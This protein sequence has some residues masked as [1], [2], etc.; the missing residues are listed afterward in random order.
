MITLNDLTKQAEVCNFKLNRIKHLQ[1]STEKVNTYFNQTFNCSH[2]MN[3]ISQ[4]YEYV[5]LNDNLETNNQIFIHYFRMLEKIMW[6]YNDNLSNYRY[7]IKNLYIL[8]NLLFPHLHDREIKYLINKYNHLS[9]KIPLAGTI[10]VSAN[11]QEVLLVKNNVSNAWSFPKG[12]IECGEQSVDTA[13]RECYEE[14]GINITGKVDISNVIYKQIKG[15]NVHFYIIYLTEQDMND[16][17]LLPQCDKEIVDIKWF[18]INSDLGSNRIFNIF[19]NQTYNEFKH[20]L[21]QTKT[22][23]QKVSEHHRESLRHDLNLF[24]MSPT[25]TVGDMCPL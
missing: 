5:T 12:K 25:F 3:L 23:S 8:I 18:P 9:H 10:I 24:T 1:F 17:V 22:S 15:K 11:K 4:L 21:S 7:K 19:I 2:F 16:I 13:I 6:Y 14:T 20:L